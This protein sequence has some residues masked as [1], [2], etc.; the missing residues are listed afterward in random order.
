MYMAQS[1]W[2]F[3]FMG[4]YFVAGVGRTLHMKHFVNSPAAMAANAAKKYHD[5]YRCRYNG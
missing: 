4:G 3:F 5:R 1:V 2:L